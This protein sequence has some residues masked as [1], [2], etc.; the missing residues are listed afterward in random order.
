MASDELKHFMAKLETGWTPPPIPREEE[1]RRVRLQIEALLEKALVLAEER[2]K[3]IGIM[4]GK[5]IDK[6]AA[7][8]QKVPGAVAGGGLS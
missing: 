8:A 1:I 3:G 7:L 6:E 4:L 2:Y 5:L